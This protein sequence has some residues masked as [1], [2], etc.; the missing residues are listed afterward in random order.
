MY[1]QFF[2]FQIADKVKRFFRIHSMNRHKMT[3]LT[4]A[5]HAEAYS[6]E[7]NR[8]DLRQFLYNIKWEWQFS[9]IDNE[10]GSTLTPELSN[11]IT[12]TYTCLLC[13]YD[14]SYLIY[15]YG[16]YYLHVHVPT[17]SRDSSI[18][19]NRSKLIIVL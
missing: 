3:V 13:Y 9:A 10:V 11:V 7:D 14:K 6:P 19:S 18:T 16:Y 12:C 2:F 5:C 1:H 15:M 17:Y 8:H 4:P